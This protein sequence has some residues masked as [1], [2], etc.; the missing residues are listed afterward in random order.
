MLPRSRRPSRR[1]S[2]NLCHRVS[3]AAVRRAPSAGAVDSLD[4]GPTCQRNAWPLHKLLCVPKASN[5]GRG[6]TF[7]TIGMGAFAY[8]QDDDD[9]DG[10]DP[11]NYG[12]S[13]D[14]IQELLCQGVKPWDDDAGAVL[15]ALRGDVDEYW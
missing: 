7:G 2:P 8:D 9:D 5:A 14:E 13:R 10:E 15:A 1:E 3:C 11:M 4:C 12:F 6:G